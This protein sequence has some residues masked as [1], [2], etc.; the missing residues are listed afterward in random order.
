[1]MGARLTN[2]E[3]SRDQMLRDALN[4]LQ[5]ALNLLDLASAPPHIGA[6]VDFAACELSAHLPASQILSIDQL[7]ARN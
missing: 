5:A 6:H 4:H 2:D 3:T 1:M 7:A